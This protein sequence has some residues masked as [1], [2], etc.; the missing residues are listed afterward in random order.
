MFL[1]GMH[2]VGRNENARRNFII[3]FYDPHDDSSKSIEKLDERIQRADWV[4]EKGFLDLEVERKEVSNKIYSIL[5]ILLKKDQ[6]SKKNKD[7]AS[8]DIIKTKEAS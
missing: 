5:S 7:E 4:L 1:F 2:G 8:S 3:T 6:L